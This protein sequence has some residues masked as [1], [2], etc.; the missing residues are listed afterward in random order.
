LALGRRRPSY[1]SSRL[2]RAAPAPD[3]QPASGA[4]WTGKLCIFAHHD[5]GGEVHDYVLHHLGCLRAAGFDIVFVSNCTALNPASVT[6]V[7]ALARLVLT[8]RNVG[9]YFGAYKDALTAVGDLNGVDRLLLAN[10]SL[11]GP[12]WALDG[13]L[14]RM[15]GLRGQFWS[16]TDNW[17]RAYHL[18]PDFIIFG[19]EAIAAPAFAQFWRGVRYV[20][21][22]SYQFRHYEVGLSQALLRAGLRGGVLCSYR[23]MSRIVIDAVRAGALSGDKLDERQAHLRD[24]YGLVQSGKPF[25]LSAYL[26]DYMIARM[27]YPYIKRA[28]FLRRGLPAPYISHWQAVVARESGYDTDLIVRHLEATLRNRFT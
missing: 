22:R 4:P 11:Y 25:D 19:R 26:W 2:D 12:F 18:E 1:V 17:Q 7:A 6:D 16:L 14:A 5:R 28:H 27:G 23:D 21:S 9:G 24:A 3:M 13:V 8:R 15:D 10:D 20:N